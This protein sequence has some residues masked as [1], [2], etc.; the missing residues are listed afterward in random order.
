MPQQAPGAAHRY[1]DSCA[2]AQV[3]EQAPPT[4]DADQ[5]A[6]IRR[7]LAAIV[8]TFILSL[9]LSS[10]F[11]SCLHLIGPL[12]AVHVL[13]LSS[14]VWC[15]APQCALVPCTQTRARI[16]REAGASLKALQLRCELPAA[17]RILKLAVGSV[18]HCRKG[19]A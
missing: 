4:S 14:T 12:L 3:R 8:S 5:F 17:S 11:A 13:L 15:A 2:A 1:T 7:T 18:E 10:L 9:S 16:K 19:L 6:P